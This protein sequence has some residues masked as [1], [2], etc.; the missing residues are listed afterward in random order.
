MRWRARSGDEGEGKAKRERKI[1]EQSGKSG[2]KG[3]REAERKRGGRRKG[4]EEGD[5]C[6]GEK[7]EGTERKKLG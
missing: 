7:E 4:D 5:R 2:G 6:M 1:G 3:E